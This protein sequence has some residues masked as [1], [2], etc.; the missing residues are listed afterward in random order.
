MAKVVSA[1]NA[2]LAVMLLAPFLAMGQSLDSEEEATYGLPL[3]LLIAAMDARGPVDPEPPQ[4]HRIRDFA[5][6]PSDQG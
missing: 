2:T 5:G 6:P 4:P 1:L 3:W